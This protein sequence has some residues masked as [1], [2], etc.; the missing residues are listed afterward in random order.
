MVKYG[1]LSKSHV[2][3]LLR[4]KDARVRRAAFTLLEMSN[5]RLRRNSELFVEI[6]R[7]IWDANWEYQ[8]A[9]PTDIYGGGVEAL[10]KGALAY[11]TPNAE[12]RWAEGKTRPMVET[13]GRPQCP[14]RLG[15]HSSVIG[16]R[17]KLGFAVKFRSP[18]GGLAG[19]Q[20][21]DRRAAGSVSLRVRTAG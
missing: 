18:V 19:G 6:T 8:R 7:F 13:F 10:V 12:I 3:Q 9:E 16:K 5:P 15:C 1:A 11:L 21:P 4:S 2:Y 17:M 20:A 14:D